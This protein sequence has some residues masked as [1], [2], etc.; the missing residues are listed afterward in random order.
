MKSLR[1]GILTFH[2]SENFGAL[3]QAYGLR[4]W[5]ADLGHSVEFINYHPSHVEGGGDFSRLW[6]PR[7]FKANAKIAYLKASMLR[8][9]LFGDKRQTEA[10]EAFRRNELHLSGPALPTRAAVESHLAAMDH[11]YDLIVLGSDQVWSASDQH[12]LDPVYFAD[13]AVPPGTRRISYAPSFG[14]ATVDPANRAELKRMISAL[15]GVS[16]RER[17]GAAIVH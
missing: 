13:F 14:R 17:S 6:D 1:I 7:A 12:G 11:P 4:K 2:F 16:C 5:L 3:L 8:Q 15:D 9:H 10:F